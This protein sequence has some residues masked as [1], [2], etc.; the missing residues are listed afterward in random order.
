MT[1]M[2][3]VRAGTRAVI[4]PAVDKEAV[5]YVEAGALYAMV[6]GARLHAS[7]LSVF[8]NH[9]QDPELRRLIKDAID[10]LSEAAI[11]KAEDLLRAGGAQVPAVAHREYPLTESLEIPSA[12]RLDDE[13]IALSLANIDGASQAMLLGAMHLCYQPEIIRALG[14]QLRASLGWA[15]RLQQL[16]LKRAWLPEMAKV[17]H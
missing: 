15:F 3:Q 12:A 7:L 8:Y 9:A 11:K 14:S 17:K 6:A 10:H 1:V 5:N 2:D 13:V 16:M 4:Q